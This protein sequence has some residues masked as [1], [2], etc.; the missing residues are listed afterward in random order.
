MQLRYWIGRKIMP[1]LV[2]SFYE[3]LLQFLNKPVLIKFNK[4]GKIGLRMLKTIPR[5]AK[6]NINGKYKVQ[7]TSKIEPFAK[8]LNSS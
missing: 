4:T 8:T 3:I 5:K 7:K 2:S 1:V 6:L